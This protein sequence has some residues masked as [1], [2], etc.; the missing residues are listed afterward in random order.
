MS[1]NRQREYIKLAEEL[2]EIEKEFRKHNYSEG[3]INKAKEIVKECFLSD[4]RFYSHNQSLNCSNDEFDN[5]NNSLMKKY[6]GQ[7]IVSE[8][9]ITE[10]F[11]QFDNIE[12]YTKL[13]SM[14]QINQRVVQL[15]MNKYTLREI[16]EMMNIGY[17]GI[18]KRVQQIRKELLPIMK[19]VFPEAFES[20][21]E[22]I[23]KVQNCDDFENRTF[24]GGG[25]NE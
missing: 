23:N 14:N 15:M 1:F 12:L 3:D 16:S 20:N 21:A 17:W 8:D 6:L 18:V 22:D 25:E 24:A 10:D 7:F 2:S 11:E 4:M 5:E 19:N 9:Y 13:K